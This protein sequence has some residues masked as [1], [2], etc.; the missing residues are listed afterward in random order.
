VQVEAMTGD[1]EGQLSHV[2]NIQQWAQ[3]GSLWKPKKASAA[4][5][6]TDNWPP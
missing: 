2:Q 5:C 4:A 6:T 1:N 3:Y